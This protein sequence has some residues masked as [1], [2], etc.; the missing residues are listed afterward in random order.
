MLSGKSAVEWSVCCRQNLR[1]SKRRILSIS[2]VGNDRTGA[3]AATT[4]FL[5]EMGANIEA[6]EEQ[7]TRGHFSMAVQA[8]W[9]EAEWALAPVREGLRRLAD[10]LGMVIRVK[11]HLSGGMQRFAIFVSKEEHVLCGLL[12]AT[13]KKQIKALPAVVV[14]NHGEL[15]SLARQSQIPFRRIDW[16][17]RRE[18]EVKALQ[19]LEDFEVDFVVL[20][21]FM[22][23]LSPQFVWHFKNKIINIHP[24]LLPSFPG[25]YAYRQ[26]WEHGVKITGVS[27]HFVNMHLDEGPII[28]QSSFSV[29]RG[30]TLQDIVRKGQ[31][32]ETKIL[33]KAVKLY[34]SR[35]LDVHWG[36]VKE[37]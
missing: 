34:L 25:P 22:K 14:S 3:V 9:E 21:R 19:L 29:K 7:V 17:K 36:T 27:A 32:L 24:S 20:A 18:A 4:K 23:I 5:F 6:L 13:A 30:M 15:Y 31:E 16:A 1:M 8:S 37:V 11:P 28:A 33:I 2:V 12:D 35:R 10:D 26:A